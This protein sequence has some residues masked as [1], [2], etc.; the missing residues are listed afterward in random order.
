P[1]VSLETPI[2]AY[3]TT[4]QS[5]ETNLST[6]VASLNSSGTPTLTLSQV[7]T[8]LQAEAEAYRTGMNAGLLVTHPNIATTVGTAVTTLEDA[9]STIAAD[10]SATA[11]SQLHTA[12][13]Q[14]DTAILDTT[15]LFGTHGLVNQESASTGYIAQT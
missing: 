8:T 1:I 14:F 12:I 2:S 5:L 4:T 6:L 10:N 11:L 9:V 3:V 13:A 7:N 15:G